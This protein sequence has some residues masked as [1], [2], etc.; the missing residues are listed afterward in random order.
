MEMLF[1]TF[2]NG[3]MS[4]MILILIASGLCLI[5][6]ILHI[7]NFAHGE[8]YMLGGFGAW[9]LFSQYPLTFLGAGPVQYVAAIMLSMVV[10]GVLGM[11]VEMYIYRPFHGDLKSTIIVSFGVM[12]ILQAGA[13]VVF[14]VT[15]K[16]ISSP[17]VG[18]LPLG[19]VSIST[20]RLVAIIC[21]AIFI[22]ALH[23]FISKT[24]SGKAM[25]AV[26]QDQ[27]AAM[28]Q[29]IN[30]SYIFSLAMGIGCA[31]AAAGGAL[32]GPIFYVNPYMGVAP[33]MKAFVV[34]ILGGIGS[35]PG[36]VVGGFVIAMTESLVTT[37][38]GA[39]AATIVIFLFLIAVLIVKPSGI[40][41]NAE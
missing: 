14:G 18:K 9:F 22:T 17:F 12:L 34:I 37:Y 40:F 24:K 33:I 13:L 16:A 32:V 25:R 10:V 26:A 35:L 1:Q 28:V 36:A 23:V 6:G 21:G 8:F 41:G 27:E 4:A 29:G 7:V 19:G 2:V 31:L 39:H 20:E 38:V 5:F 15:D 30:I 3:I 11:L